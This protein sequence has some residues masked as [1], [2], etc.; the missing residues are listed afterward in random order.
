M[1][2]QI[3][4]FI[5]RKTSQKYKFNL[6]YENKKWDGLNDL[7]E[8]AR[9]SII[10]GYAQYF[11]QNPHILDLGCGEGILL[12][13]FAAA[14][15]SFYLGIDFSDV[16]VANAKKLGIERSEFRVGDLN[17][18]EVTEKFD[19]I[20]YNESLYYLSD[21]QN[22]VRS[23]FKNLNESGVFIFSM[24]DQHGNERTGLWQ[25]L[26]DILDPVDKTK[27]TNKAGNSWTISVYKVKV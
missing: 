3:V 9:Y 17:K 12:R 24:V 16:A 10:V 1:V 19:A 20:I 25:Q 22:A 11:C 21:P 18:L 27:V 14:N 7:P 15:Y 6:Q 26:N 4:S 23:L 2:R 5:K 13:K 8:L